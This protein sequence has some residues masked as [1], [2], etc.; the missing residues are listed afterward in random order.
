MTTPTAPRGSHR[1]DLG[2]ERN[3]AQI[4]T[5][6][7]PVLRATSVLQRLQLDAI[8]RAHL[9]RRLATRRPPALVIPKSK[10]LRLRDLGGP[11][12]QIRPTLG[13][14]PAWIPLCNLSVAQRSVAD[15]LIARAQRDLGDEATA[16]IDFRH[17]KPVALARPLIEWALKGLDML[18]SHGDFTR[19]EAD[20]LAGVRSLERSMDALTQPED[21]MVLVLPE[22]FTRHRLPIQSVQTLVVRKISVAFD[23]RNR[24]RGTTYERRHLAVGP[25]PGRDLVIRELPPRA[26]I[27]RPQQRPWQRHMSPTGAGHCHPPQLLRGQPSQLWLLVFEAGTRVLIEN[28]RVDVPG[29]ERP[30]LDV[31]LRKMRVEDTLGRE[32]LFR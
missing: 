32:V 22:E 31:D 26:G 14:P 30:D 28:V 4:A 7:T 29:V 21:E 20:F 12:I 5:A 15:A 23:G 17:H 1:P 6:E 18:F 19:A 24:T 11:R 13:H 3:A 9:G 10:A 27:H 8:A 25:H 16:H 2:R